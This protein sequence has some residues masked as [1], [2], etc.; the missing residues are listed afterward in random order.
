MFKNYILLA[1]RNVIQ[2]KFFSV[3]NLVGLVTGMACCLLI[4]IYV[5]DEL[6]YDRFHRDHENMYRVALHGKI[7]GQE[8]HTSN[9]SLP[10]GPAMKSEIPGIEQF[11]RL[12]P[13][14]RG[15][16]MA[17]RYEDKS[18]LEEKIF[19]S[20]SNFFE[21]FSFELINGDAQ[22]VLREPNSIV[23][24]QST[25]TKYFGTEDPIGKTLVIG[26]KK[27]SCKVTGIAA[28]TP[29]NSHFH[30]NAIISFSTV[31]KD[32][33]NGWTGNSIQTYIRK[34]PGT[35]VR[36]IDAK[37]E[38]LVDKYV[39]KEL[40]EGLGIKIE[41]FRKQGG[42]YSYFIYPL[43]DT[44]LYSSLVDDSEPQNSIRYIY[45][46]S[47]VGIFI[48][49]IAC[50]NFMNLSTARSA[51]R[52][53]EV[54][55]RKTFG[56]QR[57]Q[58]ISQFLSESFIYSLAG[59]LLAIMTSFLLLPYFNI[60]AG[61]NLSMSAIASPTFMLATIALILIVG[62]LAGSY[63]AFYLTSFNAVEVLKGKLRAGMKSRGVRSS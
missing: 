57:S 19:Y 28:N 34:T 9:S 3:I 45:I 60:L 63:P 12:V 14:T 16:G 56:S 62:L 55:L 2:H 42:I 8:I 35:S 6:S 13:A 61:K 37:L 33:Y 50:I 5:E 20:D 4:F 25:A 54:G 59:V 23:I 22:T 43:T 51:G 18:L 48:L 26:T 21:F 31:E 40:E 47:G 30:F 10:L 36:D 58:M 38:S 24:T 7:S 52:A 44:H 46:F 1:F 17:V 39:G 27:M 15:T 53:K 49:L 32:Y 41:E 11:M 29:S